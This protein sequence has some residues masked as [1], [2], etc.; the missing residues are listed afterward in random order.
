MKYKYRYRNEVYKSDE[1]DENSDDDVG[2]TEEYWERWGGG[3]RVGGF[4]VWCKQRLSRLPGLV[5]SSWENRK[6]K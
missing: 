3:G 5:V 1:N 2:F 6:S 4:G